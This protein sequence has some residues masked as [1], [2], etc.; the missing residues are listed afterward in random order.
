MQIQLKLLACVSH[1]TYCCLYAVERLTLGL[2]PK[3]PLSLAT[4][5][6]DKGIYCSTHGKEKEYET[7]GQL[8]ALEV[9]ELMAYLG[10]SYDFFVG[11]SDQ[12]IH[13]GLYTW[14]LLDPGALK[15]W[16]QQVARSPGAIN[17]Q[18]YLSFYL[19]TFDGAEEYTEFYR[20]FVSLVPTHPRLSFPFYF[21]KAMASLTTQD[22]EVF[23]KSAQ[24]ALS[25][26]KTSE[27][28]ELLQSFNNLVKEVNISELGLTIESVELNH[29]DSDRYQV[30]I[31]FVRQ[32]QRHAQLLP[33]QTTESDALLKVV[34][35][36]IWCVSVH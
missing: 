19:E 3:T 34:F 18:T 7:I 21:L 22:F 13:F 1:R 27:A 20:R 17:V 10:D 9:K 2:R 29:Q 24:R 26:A 6:R 31:Y 16:L 23:L 12:K 30:V 33:T 15:F 28:I 8:L 11:H 5:L 25:A 4:V 14:L 35:V 36:L 32:L